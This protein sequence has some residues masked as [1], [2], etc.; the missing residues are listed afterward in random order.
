MSGSNPLDLGKYLADPNNLLSLGD[1]QLANA[2]KAN[3]QAIQDWVSQQRQISEQRGL[4]GPQGITGAGVQDAAGQAANAL[5]M[6]TTAPGFKAYHGS[7]YDF[8]KFD[9]A[10]IG[11]GEGA[12][13][14]GHGLYFAENEGVA[15]DYRDRLAGKIDL[16]APL[17][18]GTPENLGHMYEVNI[19]AP[20]EHFLDWDKPL[21]EQSQHVQDAINKHRG[22]A[23]FFKENP[24]ATGEDLYRY[25]TNPTGGGLPEPGGAAATMQAY[26]IPGIRYL[27]QGSR[28][29]GEGSRNTVVFDAKTLE[30]LRKYGIAGLIGGGAAASYGGTS[31]N[32][33]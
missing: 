22:M 3:L 13:A 17:G 33:S 1:P 6:G 10:A 11:T 31:Q 8:S 20:P 32:G 7:P 28:Q 4:W 18:K 23:G 15:R 19:N 5:L 30:I 21:S 27:D 26:G 2:S 16:M 14:Y 24:N 9:T 25:K 29:A 12:Q